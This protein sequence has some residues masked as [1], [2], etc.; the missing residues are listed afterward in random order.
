MGLAHLLRPAIDRFP[1]LANAY[2]YYRDNRFAFL[3]P[4]PTPMGFRLIG[5]EQMQRGNFEP[6][7][8]QLVNRLLDDVDCLVNVGANIGYYCCHALAKHRRVIAFEPIHTNLRYLLKNLKANGWANDAEVFPLA[9]SDRP[10]IVE[11]Y[12]GNTGASLL[13]GWSGTPEHQVTLVPC[14]T[15]NDVLGSRL[16]GQRVLVLMDIEGAELHALNGASTLLHQDPRPTWLVEITIT[17]GTRLNPN[18][19]QTFELFFENG[20]QAWT[21]TSKPR[22]VTPA[23]IQAIAQG[24]PDT[25]GVHNF[26]FTA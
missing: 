17:Q 11:I 3:E 6:E 18:L 2:R 24:G 26:L 23:E 9:V 13:K 15:L 14:A 20:Y 5:S 16:A 4:V 10:G 19:L 1:K 7:E 22:T 8:T 12:G 21:A 25:L